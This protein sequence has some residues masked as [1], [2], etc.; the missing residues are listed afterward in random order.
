[1]LEGPWVR[2]AIRGTITLAAA[3]LTVSC[4]GRPWTPKEAKVGRG[5]SGGDFDRREGVENYDGGEPGEAVALALDLGRRYQALDGYGA[6]LAWYHD[7]IT[8]KTP[9]GLYELLFPELGLDIIRFRNRWRRSE[10]NDNNVEVEAE[11]FE[12]ATKALGHAP[13][14]LLTS[15]SPPSNLK[16]S[17][18][19][20]CRGN[21]DCT[22]LKKKGQFVYEEFADYWVESLRD[23][24]KRGLVPEYVSIQNEPDFIP[25]DWEG[26]RFSATESGEYPGFGPALAAVHR[27]L[28]SLPQVPLVVGPETL[29]VHYD[30]VENYLSGLDQNLLYAVAF[31]LYEKGGDGVWDWVDPGPDSYADELRAV[32]IATQKR[33]WQTEFATDEDK[34]INGGFEAA[35]LIHHTMVDGG[36]SAFV[37]WNLI[38]DGQDGLVGM[39]GRR[40]RVRDQYYSMR[41]F[42][43]FT[44]PGFVRAH[45]FTPSE[46]VRA[47][48]WVAPDE[49]Q[50]AVVLLNAGEEMVDVTLELGGY[51]AT[52]VETRRTT[53][54]PGKSER[55]T[56]L[57]ATGRDGVVRMPSRSM[58]TIALKK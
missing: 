36:A 53:F 50:V 26:C 33:R 11:I 25:P 40:P 5:G 55:W 46:S 54:R 18:A 9:D 29:G 57:G 58:V 23:Y 38:W 35:M 3:A 20:R 44:E 8:G 42:S 51:P 48:A 13:K 6:A 16:A 10:Q 37:Y 41:H 17:G 12:R 21:A 22:L 47:S 7:R 49:S 39:M 15:W 14:I 2:R 34:G 4:V 28:Q 32:H 45:V 24:A 43:R 1:M 19:E 56:D 27:K 52:S 31:H 30:K